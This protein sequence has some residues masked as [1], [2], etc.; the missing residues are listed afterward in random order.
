MN[1]DHIVPKSHGGK[2]TWLNLVATC[3]TCNHKKADRTPEQAGL[4]LLSKPFKPKWDTVLGKLA[5]SNVPD[6]W[7]VYIPQNVKQDN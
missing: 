1:V 4:K 5:Q 6:S 3:R 7:K 2:F